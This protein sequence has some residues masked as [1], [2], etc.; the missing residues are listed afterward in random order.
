MDSTTLAG[1]FVV[2]ISGLVGIFLLLKQK[3]KPSVALGLGGPVILIGLIIIAI[4]Y[5][6]IS[7]ISLWISTG[8]VLIIFGSFFYVTAKKNSMRH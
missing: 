2:I 5:G 8:L 1:S 6:L 3:Q 7:G 4:T